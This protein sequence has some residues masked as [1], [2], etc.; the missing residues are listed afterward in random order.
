LA[1]ARTKRTVQPIRSLF[2]EVDRLERCAVLTDATAKLWDASTGKLLLT[3]P[4]HGAQARFVVFSPDNL[5]LAT[6]SDGNT[7][8]IWA[9]PSGKELLVLRGHSAVVNWVAFSPDGR[10]IIAGDRE[11][12]CHVWEAAS[13]KNLFTLLGHKGWILSVDF[14]PA[15]RRPPWLRVERLLGE[16]RIPKDSPAD[17]RQFERSMK[18]GRAEATGEVQIA[19][20]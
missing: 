11:A 3:L 20:Q 9:I 19:E 12:T 7:A 17:R 16:M 15:G 14:S 6:G 10:R 4:T 1:L 13:G 18:E 8:I 5:R 2:L